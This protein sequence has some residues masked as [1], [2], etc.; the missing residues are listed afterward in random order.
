MKI[1]D[2]TANNRKSEFSITNRSGQEYCYPYQ[3]VSPQPT[4]NDRVQEVYVDK[5]LGSEAFTYALKSGEEG[6]VHIEQILEYNEDPDYFTDL[7]IYKLTLEAIKQ[8]DVNALS[9]RQLAKRL[10]TS[11]PQLYRLLD[12]A[13][14]NK[15]M[16]QLVALLHVLDC[17]VDLV[18]N[19]RNVA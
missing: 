13:N 19:E 18:I 15:S 4:V 16:K 6:S 2:V 10:K 7:L 5:E 14:T 1:R 3:K 8:V 9:R 17:D 12:P 11:V